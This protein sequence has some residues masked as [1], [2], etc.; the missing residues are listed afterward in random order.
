MGVKSK[1][2]KRKIPCLY[3]GRQ[4]D[5]VAEG[6]VGLLTAYSH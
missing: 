4:G 2:Q 1:V 6:V 5:S 3:L